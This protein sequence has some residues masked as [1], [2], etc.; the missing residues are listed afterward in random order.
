M[1]H[2]GDLLRLLRRPPGIEF[3]DGSERARSSGRMPGRIA[4]DE[5]FGGE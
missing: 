3:H 2:S 1:R 4:V 5:E